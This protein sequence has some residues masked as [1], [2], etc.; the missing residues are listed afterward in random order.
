MLIKKIAD[1]DPYKFESSGDGAVFYDK[2]GNRIGVV[3]EDSTLQLPTRALIVFNVAFGTLDP[4]K[5]NEAGNLDQS[6]TNA[7]D[8]R[9]VIST[10]GEIIASNRDLC[11]NADLVILAGAD[12]AAKRR[13]N[14]YTIAFLDMKDK[15]KMPRFYRTDDIKLPNGVIAVVAGSTDLTPEELQYVKDNLS[16]VKS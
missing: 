12:A 11:D 10:V 9:K 5:R 1:L 8:L 2:V 16:V 3:F 6:L 14:I 7:G 13:A 15:K 4:N